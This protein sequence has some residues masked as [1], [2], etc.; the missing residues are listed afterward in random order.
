MQRFEHPVFLR[1]KT[2]T[3]L[4]Y[5]AHLNAIRLQSKRVTI[6]GRKKNPVGHLHGVLKFGTPLDLIGGNSSVWNTHLI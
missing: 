6:G 5:R 4:P 1:D 3:H 2:G